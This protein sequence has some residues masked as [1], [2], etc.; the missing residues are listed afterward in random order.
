MF[1][2]LHLHLII[3][4]FVACRRFFIEK[5]DHSRTQFMLLWGANGKISAMVAMVTELQ[6]SL[7]VAMCVSNLPRCGQLIYTYFDINRSLKFYL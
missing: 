3:I 6:L 1:C 4:T 5:Q 7:L 2:R